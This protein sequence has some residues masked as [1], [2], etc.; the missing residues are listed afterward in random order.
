[1]ILRGREGRF[2]GI[3]GRP[4]TP[5][6]S[7]YGPGTWWTVVRRHGGRFLVRLSLSVEIDLSDF[8]VTEEDVE[9]AV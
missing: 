7:V 2:A 9:E 8:L 5:T 4:L 1:M 6:L 3:R